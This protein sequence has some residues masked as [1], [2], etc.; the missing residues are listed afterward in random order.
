MINAT[1]FPGTVIPANKPKERYGHMTAKP[2]ELLR[3]SYPYFLCPRAFVLDSF[4]GL[5][6]TGVVA[7]REGR[8]F[9]GYE[10]ESEMAGC[11]Q[12]RIQATFY[13]Q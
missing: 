10:L 4:A 9:I 13:E 8:N 11:A 12:E 5:G 1:Q 7:V 2:V 6:S 3:T